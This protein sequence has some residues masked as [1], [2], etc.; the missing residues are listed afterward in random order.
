MQLNGEGDLVDEEVSSFVWEKAIFN[1]EEG[2]K[3]REKSASHLPSIKLPLDPFASSNVVQ[4]FINTL[5]CNAT[6][7]VFTVG[8]SMLLIIHSYL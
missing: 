2:T 1:G 6:A 3:K 8:M 7:G 4:S 5:H